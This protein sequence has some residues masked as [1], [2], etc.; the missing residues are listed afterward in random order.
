MIDLMK[1][2]S[3]TYDKTYLRYS[4]VHRDKAI[5]SGLIKLEDREPELVASLLKKKLGKSSYEM[6]VTSLPAKKTYYKAI[7]FPFNSQKKISE[8]LQFQIEALPIDL[9]NAIVSTHRNGARVEVFSIA[10]SEIDQLLLSF[11]RLR[12]DPEW[13]TSQLQGLFR[14]ASSLSEPHNLVLHIDDTTTTLMFI[15]NGS[16]G[17][18]FYISHGASSLSEEVQKEELIQLDPSKLKEVERL[19]IRYLEFIKSE[20]KVTSF[21]LIKS[22]YATKCHL[23]EGIEGVEIGEQNFYA[24]EIGSAFD[25]IKNDSQT[26]QFRKGEYAPQEQIKALK[27][28]VTRL[29]ALGAFAVIFL[30]FTSV[31]LQKKRVTSLEKGVKSMLCQAGLHSLSDEIKVSSGGELSIVLEDLGYFLTKQKGFYDISASPP[32]VY[33]TLAE[34]GDLLGDTPLNEV[35]AY[36]YELKKYPTLDSPKKKY[37]V[38]LEL[39]FSSD[40]NTA[41]FVEKAKKHYAK[42]TEQKVEINEFENRVQFILS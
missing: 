27:K 38:E 40:H 4:L 13:M 11:D 35:V 33:E 32:R 5:L 8:A 16:I 15:E 26:I 2:L 23:L 21:R 36:R 22:G 41:Q 20:Y 39:Q 3:C 18:T 14:Y 34:M 7:Q 37:V 12:L 24:V 19:L 6:V 17:K 29:I 25:V 1:I 10:K 9:P 30:L 28:G 31:T 42:K